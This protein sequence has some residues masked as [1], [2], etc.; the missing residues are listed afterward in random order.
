MKTWLAMA[1]ILCACGK[2][3]ETTSTATTATATK[4][5]KALPPPS[6]DQAKAV[7]EG[8]GELGEFQFTN[9]AVTIPMKKSQM[10][11]PALENA[12]QL[13][14]GGW[15]RFH[16]DDVELA[17][18]KD[19]P[20]FVVRGNG[21]MDVVPVAKKEIVSTG[22]VT[23]TSEGV[24]VPITWHWIPTEIG[25][26]FK[27]GSVKELFGKERHATATLMNNGESWSV[28]RI[29]EAP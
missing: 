3:P 23:P 2:A 20:R 6:A 9:A 1:L 22:T 12:K 27:S 7:I 4:A 29:V 15:I 11:A 19:D 8:S 16:A 26:T 10:N 25:K 14:A 21:F 24:D 17:K 18:A 28:L 5:P 13:A